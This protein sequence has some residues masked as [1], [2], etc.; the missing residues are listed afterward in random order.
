MKTSF[1]K[2]PLDRL[3]NPDFVYLQMD[4]DKR[5]PFTEVAEC[6]QTIKDHRL[7]SPHTNPIA[8]K[9]NIEVGHVRR[10]IHKFSAGRIK[11]QQ[12]ANLL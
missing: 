10:H 5:P 7:V 6:L 8:A 11:T 2:Q 9:S 3:L 1:V 4:P 12:S